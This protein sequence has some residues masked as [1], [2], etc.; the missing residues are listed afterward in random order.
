M[1]ASCAPTLHSFIGMLMSMLLILMLAARC[2]A[3]MVTYDVSNGE[4]FTKGEF[5][6][7]CPAGS[8]RS[9]SDQQ[10]APEQTRF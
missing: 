4:D 8:Y 9:G 3:Q 1:Q 5:I 10:H 6:V 7:T 2:S